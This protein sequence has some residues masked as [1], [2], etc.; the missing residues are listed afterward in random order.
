MIRALILIVAISLMANLSALV[1]LYLHPDIP[2][3]DSEHLI[4]G[5]AAALVTATALGALSMHLRRLQLAHAHIS[6]LERVLPIC[7]N[8]K[9][10]RTAGKPAEKQES[11]EP[12]EAYISGHTDSEFTHGLC[13]KCLNELYPERP[14]SPDAARS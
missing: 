8:C 13:P 10:I 5:G 2:Y 6:T 4:V 12:L 11:W 7:A 14:S 9:R 3:F 1:D